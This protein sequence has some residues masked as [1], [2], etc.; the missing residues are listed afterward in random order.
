MPEVRQ[1][2]AAA[3]RS[4]QTARP[5]R[6]EPPQESSHSAPPH[7]LQAILP[8]PGT[9]TTTLCRSSGDIRADRPTPPPPHSEPAGSP[10]SVHVDE[11]CSP[12]SSPPASQRSAHTRCHPASPAL[13]T[14]I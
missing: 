8:P 1:R 13:H 9:R 14:A 12:P 10:I 5:P 6:K 4:P 3:E 7:A 11:D 2:V